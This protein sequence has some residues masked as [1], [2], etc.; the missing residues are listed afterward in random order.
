[1]IDQ[2]TVFLPYLE[3]MSKHNHAKNN[4][5]AIE[6]TPK[7]VMKIKFK[8][9]ESKTNEVLLRTLSLQ[10]VQKFVSLISKRFSDL[11]AR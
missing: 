3:L 11:K 10:P 6:K 5:A 7:E 2:K 1:M 9:G 4:L 8:K